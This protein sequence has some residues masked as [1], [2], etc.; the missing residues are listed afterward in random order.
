MK[1]SG[2]LFA[3]NP[4]VEAPQDKGVS[5]NASEPDSASLRIQGA[6]ILPELVKPTPTVKQRAIAAVGFLGV[7]GD[8]GHRQINRGTWE[9]RSDG[10][11]TIN[12]L[13]E[14]ITKGRSVRESARPIV[15]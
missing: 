5:R 13:W 7:V 2:R 6:V 9:V 8:S 1:S 4:A 12:F 15:V 10:G 11:S 14:C 3:S